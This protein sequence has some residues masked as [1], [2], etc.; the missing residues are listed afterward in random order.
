M[1]RTLHAHASA[2][3]LVGILAA[4]LATSC[5]DPQTPGTPGGSPCSQITTCGECISNVACGWC[6]SSCIAATAG[7]RGTA[8]A[9]CTGTWTWQLGTCTPSG[10]PPPH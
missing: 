10:P 9:A 5:K 2:I 8:P 7:Q 3:L 1:R 4:A 6:G